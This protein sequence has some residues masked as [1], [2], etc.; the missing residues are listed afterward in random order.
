MKIKIENC[1]Y[2]G[3]GLC[4]PPEANQRDPRPNYYHIVIFYLMY[5]MYY[6]ALSTLCNSYL[7]LSSSAHKKLN[8]FNGLF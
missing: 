6:A 5:I 2:F 8:W 4:C 3:S 7:L 1:K